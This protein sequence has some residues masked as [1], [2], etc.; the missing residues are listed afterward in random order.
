MTSGEPHHRFHR[1]LSLFRAGFA[2]GAFAL[3]SLLSG[4]GLFGGAKAGSTEETKSE[5]TPEGMV[6]TTGA[7]PEVKAF[8]IEVQ[9]PD[10]IRELLEKYLELNRFRAV[11]DLTESEMSRLLVL[12]S[13]NVRNLVAT[14]GY[15]SPEIE[16]N[17]NGEIGKQPTIVVKVDPGPITNVKAV[18][19]KFRGAIETTLDADGIEQRQK[20]RDAWRLPEGN[21]FTQDAW[22]GAKQE[23]LRE[24]IAKR[25][26]AGKIADSEAMIDA[27]DKSAR[28]DVQIDS[29]PLYRYGQMNV[30]GIERY[31]PVI[32]PRVARLKPGEIYDQKKITDA[33]LRLTGTGYFDSA[34]I[35]VDPTAGDPDA[36]PVKVTVREAPR[37]KVVFGVGFTTDGGPHVSAEYTDQRVPGI[38]WRAVTKLQLE[39]KNPYFQ[40]AWTDIPNEDGWRWGV[41]GRYERLDDDELITTAQKLQIGKSKSDDKYDRNVYIQYD[42]ASVRGS[43]AA[44]TSEA[45]V[46][47]GSALSANYVWTGRYFDS[48]PYPTSG[49]GL[50]AEAGGGYTLSSPQKPFLRLVAR[51]LGIVPLPGEQGR[52][53]LRAEGGA[54]E[55][56]NDARVPSTQLFRTGGDTTVRG[57]AYRDI[58][59]DRGNGVIGPGRYVAIGSIEWQRP[60]L[61]DGVPTAF[62]NTFFV[63]F[64]DVANKPGDLRPVYGVGTGVRVRTPL[65]P[66]TAAVA[67][68]LDSRKFR[69]HLTV[70]F[71]F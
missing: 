57:Y 26:P 71:T 6:G 29:G 37:K 1:K 60:F 19:I 45:D 55:A 28:L 34:F 33:Q 51:W 14:Q 32:V 39:T 25:Y 2:V 11:T 65:G 7:K 21:S 46:G 23:A 4:C 58:G 69:L 70:G 22:A 8:T 35:F 47:D 50:G 49:Y 31:D 30:S 24:L 67:Y 40:T 38:G 61:K 41:L 42:R 68:G 17:Q 62:E 3:L 54:V 16:I 12:A 13:R 5:V 20:I 10:K 63:D 48:L 53:A 27:P 64:G 43:G 66:L 18:D 52:L 36:V 56:S 44:T 9:A 15:F 59:I